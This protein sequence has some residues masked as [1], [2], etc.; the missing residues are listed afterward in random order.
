MTIGE[1]IIGECILSVSEA[2]TVYHSIQELYDKGVWHTPDWAV[3]LS[4]H[5]KVATADVVVLFTAWR[6]LAIAY[7][8]GCPNFQE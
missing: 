6:A 8:K 5:L 7:R 4:E 1:K 3:E 2:E